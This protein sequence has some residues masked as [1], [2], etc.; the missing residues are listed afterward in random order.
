MEHRTWLGIWKQSGPIH[1]HEDSF[2][3]FCIQYYGLWMAPYDSTGMVSSQV[4]K[5][6][7]DK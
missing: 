5:F 2:K 3:R 6:S 7:A 1:F 4:H